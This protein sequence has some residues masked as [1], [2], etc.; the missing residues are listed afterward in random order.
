MIKTSGSCLSQSKRDW[1]GSR[2]KPDSWVEVCH[3][4][5][6]IRGSEPVRS[7]PDDPM[8]CTAILNLQIKANSYIHQVIKIQSFSP[9]IL[10][11]K[12]TRSISIKFNWCTYEIIK[13]TCSWSMNLWYW[14]ILLTHV[15]R[16]RLWP[17]LP[18]GK[19]C[20]TRPITELLTSFSPTI[21]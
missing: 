2:P 7:K 6:N 10:L 16:T 13:T 4:W 9:N 15:D 21:K 8:K 20:N 19:T 3:T 14:V 5:P 18:F 17:I 12:L 1:T 11:R